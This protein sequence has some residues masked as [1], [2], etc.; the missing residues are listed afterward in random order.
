MDNRSLASNWLAIGFFSISC[1]RWN[2]TYSPGNCS[3]N[4]NLQITDRK[5]GIVILKY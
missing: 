2:N 4:D 3:N 5:K 1:N